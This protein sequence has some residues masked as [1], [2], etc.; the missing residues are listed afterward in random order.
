MKAQW[1]IMKKNKDFTLGNDSLFFCRLICKAYVLAEIEPVLL[2]FFFLL[3]IAIAKEV[4]DFNAC[5]SQSMTN[6]ICILLR[7]YTSTVLHKIKKCLN[8][9]KAQAKKPA[10]NLIQRFSLATSRLVI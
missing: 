5:K 6:L 10:C 2:G 9:L 1:C 8:F 7:S 3:F 4:L